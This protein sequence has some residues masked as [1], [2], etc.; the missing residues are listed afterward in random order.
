MT[1]TP[2]QISKITVSLIPLHR[3]TFKGHL[4]DDWTPAAAQYEIACLSWAEK[5]LP[6]TTPEIHKAKVLS[7][8]QELQKTQK[9]DQYVLDGR[10]SIKVT[11]SLVTVRRYKGILNI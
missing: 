5:D 9:F 1:G 4:L 3:S 8:E 7:C 2:P 10:L 6:C 11:T